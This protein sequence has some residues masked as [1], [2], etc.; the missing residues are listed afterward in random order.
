MVCVNLKLVYCLTQDDRLVFKM[1]NEI[2]LIG[3]VK[4]YSNKMGIFYN[5]FKCMFQSLFTTK[6]FCSMVF[7]ES[8]LVQPFNQ[9]P[10]YFIE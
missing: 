8:I 7:I 1:K 9:R 6:A 10:F 4:V 3:V 5:I 2:K